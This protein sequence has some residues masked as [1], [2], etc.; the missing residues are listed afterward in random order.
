MRPND[1]PCG[2]SSPN[3]TIVPDPALKS[4]LEVQLVYKSPKL[5]R[6]G[7]TFPEIEIK[8]TAKLDC[9]TLNLLGVSYLYR[10]VSGFLPIPSVVLVPGT[11]D[12]PLEI[13]DT[14]DV[15][16][17]SPEILLSV[18]DSQ[19]QQKKLDLQSQDLLTDQQVANMLQKFLQDEQRLGNQSVNLSSQNR[20]SQSNLPVKP[21]NQSS[22]LSSQTNQTVKLSSPSDDSNTQDSD[23]PET[24]EPWSQEEETESE[25]PL[26]IINQKKVVVFKE[27]EHLTAHE[28]RRV[29][30]EENV[31]PSKV[32]RRLGWQDVYD[33]HTCRKIQ[34]KDSLDT[35]SP[36]VPRKTKYKTGRATFLIKDKVPF[37]TPVYK[38]SSPLLRTTSLLDKHTTIFD[39]YTNVFK[40]L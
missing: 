6:Q 1:T 10:Q 16:D 18:I 2:F 36:S 15:V 4:Q 9:E 38:S 39:G 21:S 33:N 3:S 8:L 25:E 37:E 40:P 34:I 11:P 35:V 5:S 17:S 24:Q 20:T 32:Q 12:S 31:R 26:P 13:P 23:I 14:L 30:R 19:P 29:E 22:K 27:T 28:K 7:K